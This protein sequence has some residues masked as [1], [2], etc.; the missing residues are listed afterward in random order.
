[1]RLDEF[2]IQNNY[3]DSR[4]KAKQ[5]VLRGEIFIN[6]TLI[7]KPAYV[8]IENENYNV[9]R[10]CENSFVSLGGFK[11]KK[12]IVDFKFN[13][14]N[15][16]V[17]DVGA[18]T[19]GFT[20]CLL[21]EGA[22]KVYA[23]DLNDTLLHEKLKNDSRVISI[24]KNAR[25][26]DKSDF[27]ESLDLIVADLSFISASYVLEV[28]SKLLDD[29]KQLILII[30]PQFETGE[31]KKFKNGIIKDVKMQREVCSKIYDCAVLNNLFPQAF[32]TAPKSEGKN[33]EFLMLFTKNSQTTIDK[34]QIYS[35]I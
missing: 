18:S 20:D 8:M 27:S 4:T 1:M 16:I 31:R 2:L 6:G 9:Q 12:A 30:K 19:G 26:L 25:D 23:V 15:L 14:S 17:A 32:T 35:L 24:I 10:V 11:L 29:N 7:T 33:L 22:K 3:F 5:A 28:F 34:E 13:A 21:G